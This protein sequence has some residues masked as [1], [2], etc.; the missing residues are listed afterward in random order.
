MCN[1]VSWVS[2]ENKRNKLEFNRTLVF[3]VLDWDELATVANTES[4]FKCK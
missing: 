2:S 3:P 4:I 1:G